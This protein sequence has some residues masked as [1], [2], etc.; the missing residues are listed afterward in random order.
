MKIAVFTSNQP[1]HVALIERLAAIADQCFAILECNTVYPG[2]RQDFFAKSPVMERY[3]RH[4]RAAEQQLFGEVRFAPRAVQTLSIRMGDLSLLS[5]Q[6]LA[7]ALDADVFVVF[8]ASFIKGWL[9]DL[10]VERHALNIHMGLSPYYRGSSCNFWALYDR[11]PHMV[12]ATIH[13]LSTGLDSGPMLFHALPGHFDADPFVF[14]MRSVVVAQDALQARIR[15]G[16]LDM[17]E[18]VDQD[19]SA[20]LR[21]SRNAEFND[22]VAAEFLAR[23]D[24]G[25]AMTPAGEPDYAAGL[26]SPVHG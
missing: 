19:R 16:S 4:V 14:T 8:G 11:R 2:Q 24:S 10:L 22:P 3:F 26:L 12:G 21:Y 15:D 18:P 13:Q 20:E 1:R 9:C 7:D 23:F 25:E 17:L 6:T 5:R